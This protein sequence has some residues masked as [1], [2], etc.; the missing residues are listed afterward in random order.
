MTDFENHDATADPGAFPTVAAAFGHA[1]PAP[2]HRNWRLPIIIGGAALIVA[3]ALILTFAVFLPSRDAENKFND[4][5][6]AFQQ[7]QTNLLAKVS[8]AQSVLGYASSDRVDD[9]D[10]LITLNNDLQTAAQ[11]TADQVPAMA[12]GASAIKQQA[13]DLQAKADAMTSL[14]ATLQ[15]DITAVQAS[16]LS[17]A[18][19]ALTAAIVDAN[20]TYSDYSYGDK[21]TLS[22]LQDQITQAQAALDGLAT[23]DPSTY[24][25]TVDDSV[26]ALQTAQANV[27]AAAPV[28]C[29]DVLLPTGVDPMVCKGMPSNAKRVYKDSYFGWYFEM[30]SKNV[31]CYSDGQDVTCEIGSYTWKTPAALQAA[32]KPAADIGCNDNIFILS[33][34]GK[35]SLA[36]FSG[37]DGP[38]CYV[39]HGGDNP[40]KPTI[41]QYGQVANFTSFA[42][43]SASD[44]VTCWNINNHHGYKMS[45]SQFLYW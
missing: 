43:L 26:T 33:M 11:S 32:C 42:C 25:T 9:Q 8:A 5:A 34:N 20:Q 37:C 3:V 44:G 28:K 10:T 1:T 18:T 19:A 40:I 39:E 21:T 41:L 16:V 14:V 27:V 12:S 17:W 30:P 7:A 4:A 45:K 13:S 38:L 23:A 2:A 15:R 36:M 29:G 35:T 6:A 22:A 24:A 31:A